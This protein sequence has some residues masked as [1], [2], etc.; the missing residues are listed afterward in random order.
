MTEET[1][2]S[3]DTWAQEISK[4]KASWVGF[5]AEMLGVR[6]SNIPRLFKSVNMYGFWPVFEAII[7]SSTRELTGDP[8]NYVLKVAS[9]KWREERERQDE[10]A[11]YQSSVQLSKASSKQANTN[12]EKRI[13][14]ARKRK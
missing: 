11:S 6:P 7:D 4:S 9:N 10:E 8:L 2:K 5:Y 3:L 13:A 1:P 14:R 12:L